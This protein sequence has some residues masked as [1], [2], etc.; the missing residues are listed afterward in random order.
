MKSALDP[1]Y[2]IICFPHGGG[3]VQSFRT[4]SDY[5]PEDVELICLDLPGRG[6]RSAEAP[7]RSMDVLVS[8]VT[9]ALRGYSDRP[10]IFFGHSAGALVAYEVARS[11]EKAGRPSPFHVVVS[12]HKSADVPTDE[13]PMYR[14]ADD[15]L[16]DVIRIL[17]MIPKEA[18]ANEVLLQDFILPPLRAD[19]ELVETYDRNLPT[20]LNAA[21]TAMGGVQDET[22]NAND[23]NEWRRLTTSRFAR[24]MFDSDHF[25]THSMTAEVVSTLLGEVEEV[26]AQLPASIRIGETLAYPELPLHDQFRKQAALN[27]DAPAV[28]SETGTLTYRELDDLS[29]ILSRHLLGHG[30]SRG[31]R[32][33][34]LM[35]TSPEYAVALFGILKTGAAYVVLD[36]AQPM[37]ALRRILENAGVEIVV[38]NNRFAAKL[39]P[40]WS[41]IAQSLDEGWEAQ[42]GRA[43]PA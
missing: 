28:V 31:S 37:A 26:K 30:Q 11:L 18:L 5:L 36:K 6:K 32:V 24:I 43:S 2:R 40:D 13:P 17:G 22:I 12:A 23:L 19:F 3:S 25:Y 29:D 15:K 39:P 34:I 8:M 16:I 41:G 35:D 14:Y 21:I 4:W 10:F 7:I 33:G 9:E 1:S 38:T 27:P 42:L 20:P